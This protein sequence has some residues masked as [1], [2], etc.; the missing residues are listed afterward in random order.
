MPEAAE[1]PAPPQSAMMRLED[2]SLL[3]VEFGD[4]GAFPVPEAWF[5]FCGDEM[6]SDSVGQE[7]AIVSLLSN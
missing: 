6:G 2:C 3:G 7:P 5:L 1:R 4:R